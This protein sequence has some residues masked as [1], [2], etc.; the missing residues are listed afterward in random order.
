DSI[1][2]D[3]DA[4]GHKLR[5]FNVHF[6]CVAGPYHRLSQFRE[7]LENFDPKRENIICGDLNTFGHP[8]VN[9]FLWKYFGYRI[10]ELFINEKKIL[11]THFDLNKLKNPFRGMITFIKFPMQLDYILLPK[12]TKISAKQRFLRPYGSDHLALSVEI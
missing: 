3:I 9:I 11:R 1:Y 7:V 5:I 10:Q 6:K 8:I 12:K 2:V 4:P